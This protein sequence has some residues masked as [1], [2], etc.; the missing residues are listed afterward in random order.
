M[1]PSLQSAFES[2]EQKRSTLLNHL[3]SLPHESLNHSP[4]PGQWSPLEVVNHLV[5]SEGL[6]RAYI[7]KKLKYRTRIPKTGLPHAIRTK[8]GLMYMRGSIK[9]KAPSYMKKMSTEMDFQT[10]RNKWD[11]GRNE[12]EGILA[13][14]PEELMK[15]AVLKHPLGGRINIS[16]TMQFL[17]AHFDRHHKQIMKLVTDGASTKPQT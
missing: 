10:L 13:A 3:A 4:G 16:Q 1:N 17:E 9:M 12:L 15:N 2:M 6:S 7:Q 5:E 14:F 8:F 11:E